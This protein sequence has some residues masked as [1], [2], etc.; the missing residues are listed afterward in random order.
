[1]KKNNLFKDQELNLIM[2]R[3]LNGDDCFMAIFQILFETKD[4]DDFYESVS[5]AL[6]K[7]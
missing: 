7:K 6:E 5:L 1:M 2:N 3:L 4:F